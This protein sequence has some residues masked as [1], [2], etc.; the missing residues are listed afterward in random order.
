MPQEPKDEWIDAGGLSFHCRDWGGSGQ[1]I[2]LL[3]GLASTCHIW[4]QAA[5]IL[6]RSFA[7]VD[8]DLRGHGE[9][10]KPDHGYDFASVSGDVGGRDSSQKPVEAYR[11]GPF[12][13]W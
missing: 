10:A 5:P 4:D 2:L 6:A 12:M 8:M 13:G 11:C 9:S 1:P 7:V 3:H